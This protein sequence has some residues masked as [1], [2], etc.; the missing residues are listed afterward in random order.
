MD[1][2]EQICRTVAIISA[3]LLLLMIVLWF[4]LPSG[5]IIVVFGMDTSF[6]MRFFLMTFLLS[7]AGYITTKIRKIEFAAKIILAICSVII[8]VSAVL[9]GVVMIC[10]ANESYLSAGIVSNDGNYTL[11]KKIRINLMNQKAVDY[12]K[13]S[14]FMTYDYVFDCDIDAVPEIIWQ[15]EGFIYKDKFYSYN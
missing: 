10:K 5:K 1:R 8:I 7:V 12:Y 14:G 13:K 3:L 11:Y 15:E 9:V 4:W 6:Y 2:I